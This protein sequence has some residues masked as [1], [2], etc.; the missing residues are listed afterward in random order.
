LAQQSFVRSIAI[1]SSVYVVWENLLFA[2]I[3]LLDFESLENHGLLATKLFPEQPVPYYFT[4]VAKY[5]TEKYAEALRVAETGRRFVVGNDRLLGEFFGMI[6]DIQFKLG[7]TTA[8]DQAYDR[9]LVIN[10]MNVTVL[11]NYAYYLSLRGETLEKAEEMSKRAVEQSPD[12]A[13]YLDTYAWIMYRKGRYEEALVWIEKAL[14]QLTEENGVI[15]EHYGDILYKLGEKEQ[16]LDYWKKAQAAGE[17]SEFIDRKVT[18]GI[19]YE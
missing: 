3:Q 10:P 11:N 15:L 19:L 14:E 5:Q 2:D 7:N 18:D 17:A 6:G 12:V 9:A 4:A 13:A 8:S 16:A 1:D